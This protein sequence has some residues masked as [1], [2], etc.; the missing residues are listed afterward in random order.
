[1]TAL[2]FASDGTLALATEAGSV[3]AISSTG[4]AQPLREATQANIRCLAW[5]KQGEPMLAAG[6]AD[7]NITILKRGAAPFNLS[8]VPGGVQDSGVAS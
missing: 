6:D 3:F 2:A 4:G 1:M 7:G 5:S 8:N